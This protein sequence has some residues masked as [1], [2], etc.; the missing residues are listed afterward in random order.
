VVKRPGAP[1]D[2]RGGRGRCSICDHP[3]ADAID[4]AL[5]RETPLSKLEKQFGVTGTS[6]R[7]HKKAH[8]NPALKAVHRKQ[9]REGTAHSVLN[10]LND[11]IRHMKAILGASVKAGLVG[12]SLA[13]NRELRQN[14]EFLA[15]LTGQLDD[16][17][18]TTINLVTTSEWTRLRTRLLTALIPYPDVLRIVT[19]ELAKENA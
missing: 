9:E 13:T 2:R 19:A 7:R 8:S 16:R 3:Q 5:V 11:A 4:R 12:Q 6:L 14:L 1:I 15:R 18:T 10:E 17:A